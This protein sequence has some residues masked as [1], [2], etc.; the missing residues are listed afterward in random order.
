MW[1]RGLGRMALLTT[2]P[3][4]P[5]WTLTLPHPDDNKPTKM[6]K[7]A[8]SLS[9]IFT[10]CFSS[11]TASSK[12]VSTR[13]RGIRKVDNSKQA[14]IIHTE[15]ENVP[16]A[17][18]S[19]STIAHRSFQFPVISKLPWQEWQRRTMASRNNEVKWMASSLQFCWFV[20]ESHAAIVKTVA[21]SLQV[22]HFQLVSV[23]V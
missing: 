17:F 22:L 2:S 13:G 14:S 10:F 9:Q 11:A 8:H 3:L 12:G 23:A 16:G 19:L 20:T 15:T 1:M 4:Y 18:V 7:Q 6:N 5:W 21:I